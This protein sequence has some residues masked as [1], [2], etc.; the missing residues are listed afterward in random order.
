MNIHYDNSSAINILKNPILHSR[1]KHIEIFT[2]SLE[3][4]LKKKCFSLKFVPNE[5]QLADILIELQLA[6]IFIKPLD[7]LSFE[8]FRK[9]LGIC[10]IY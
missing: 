3:I 8:F 2:I 7:S 1:T 9:S 10:L 6:D 5:P 4:L